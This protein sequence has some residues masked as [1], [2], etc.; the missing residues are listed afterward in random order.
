MS[1]EFSKRR[2]D[3]ASPAPSTPWLRLYGVRLAF[4]WVPAFV[5]GRLRATAL[6]A[7][8]VRVG[9]KTAFWH[10]PTLLG[11]G[12]VHQ[13]LTIGSGCGFNKGAVFD[14]S[15]PITIGNRVD[16]GHDVMFL[17]SSARGVE[18]LLPGERPEP[19]PV[20]VGDGVWLGARATILPGV[21]IGAGSV[22]G[23]GIVVAKDVPE[24]TL[25]TGL[26]PISLARWR[27]ATQ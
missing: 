20:V 12:R 8:G 7:A 15:A 6:R 19:K 11:S 18:P 21:T 14:L 23:A 22:I 2:S 26:A 3:G 9:K 27:P 10:L 25:L 4:G 17:T 24:N 5:G 1:R 13:R 16:C